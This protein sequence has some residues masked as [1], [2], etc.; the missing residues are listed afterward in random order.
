[1]ALVSSAGLYSET[2]SNEYSATARAEDRVEVDDHGDDR[3]RDPRDRRDGE[4]RPDP[5]GAF[6][7]RL[8]RRLVI[9]VWSIVQVVHAVPSRPLDELVEYRFATWRQRLALDVGH[10]L[11]EVVSGAAQL[12]HHHIERLHRGRGRLLAA[13]VGDDAVQAPVGM[14]NRNWRA[15]A[16]VG[17]KPGNTANLIGGATGANTAT[18]KA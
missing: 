3:E 4:Q 17:H 5:G 8:R 12:G 1:M 14:H 16:E 2:T 10:S 9:R 15:C 13:Q 7:Q 18:Q 6:V 11:F